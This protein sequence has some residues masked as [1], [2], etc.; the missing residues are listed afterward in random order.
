MFAR[1]FSSDG[2]IRWPTPWRARKATRLPRSVPITYGPD[3]SPNG[4]EIHRSSRS[5][6]SAM[7][8]KPLPPMMPIVVSMSD[9]CRLLQ[10]NQHAAATGRVDECY[11]GM[12]RAGTRRLVDQPDA[13]RLQLRQHGVDV[14]DAQ[15]DVMQARTAL[16][17]V[18]RDRRVGRGRLEQLEA[19]LADAGEMRAHLL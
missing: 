15:R 13:A 8:Y 2:R 19:R 4:V 17:D 6:T 9:L 18:L 10:F 3:G 7:S 11:Q 16:V 12:F 5:V 1:K 14:V